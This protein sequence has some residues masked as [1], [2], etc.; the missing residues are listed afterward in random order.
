MPKNKEGKAV[1][2]ATFK[3]YEKTFPQTISTTDLFSHKTV[4]F[5]AVPGAFTQP[6]SPIQVLGYNEYADTFSAN[7]VDDIICLSV[8]GPFALARWA[9]EEKADRIRFIPDVKGDFTRGMGMLI[10]LSEKGMGQ[11]SRRYSMLV[12]NGLIEKMF[13]EQ[14]SLGAFPT[15]SSAETMMNY[16]NPAAQKPKRVTAL[17]QIWTAVLS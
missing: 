2:A 5:F 10:D 13:I 14:R 11:R 17:M 9:K 15:V 4:V 1:P 16:I 6:Y 7:G 12:K 3:I 8:N